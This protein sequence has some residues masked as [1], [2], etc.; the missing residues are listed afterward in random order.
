[1]QKHN[2]PLRYPGGKSR[3]SD[4]IE[5]LIHGNGLEDCVFYE[6]YAGGAGAALNLL[7]SGT[8][9]QIVLNDLDYHINAFWNSIVNETS[10]FIKLIQDVQVNIDNW[11][12][13]KEVFLNPSEYS[14]IE[15]GFSTFF[16][17]R[18]NRS[19]ILM[20]GPIG[21]LNQDGNYKM[22][23]RFNKVELIERIERI[24]ALRGK[25]TVESRESLDLIRE[26]KS[27][28][29]QEKQFIFLDPPYYHQGENLYFSFYKDDDHKQ[30]AEYLRIN[31]DLNWFL[32]YDNVERINELYEGC[33]SAL[34]PMTYTLQKKTKAK[35]VMYFPKTMYVPNFLRLGRKTEL[36]SLI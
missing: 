35:E 23:V 32:T 11:K 12:K 33:K 16:L 6:L 26:I 1:M 13:Q 9:K 19:G 17:N 7:F 31:Q 14:R 24:G 21:G 20:A 15:V 22:D 10:C 3:I 2:S 8:V 27:K 18:V 29:N 30:L 4:F 36:L 34:L 5:D 28:S 25:I